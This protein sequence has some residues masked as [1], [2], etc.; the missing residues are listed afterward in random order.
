MPKEIR[1]LADDKGE[2]NMTFLGMALSRYRNGVAK[3]HGDISRKMF[4]QY[5]I[6]YITNG[7]HHPFWISKSFPIWSFGCAL[8]AKINCICPLHILPS[9]SMS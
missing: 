8:P 5:E 3:K 4:P 7:I 6:D 2:F 9:L 1:Q